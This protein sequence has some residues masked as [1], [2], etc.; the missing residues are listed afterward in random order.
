MNSKK[1]QVDK[2]LLGKRIKNIRQAAALNMAEFGELI[3]GANKGL[4]SKWEKGSSI[5]GY[6]RLKKIAELGGTSVEE[7][8]S[9]ESMRGVPPFN[10]SLEELNVLE[11]VIIKALEEEHSE[12]FRKSLI[13]S[14]EKI[15]IRRVELQDSTN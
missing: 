11:K 13:S 9:I 12:A 15:N 1:D 14:L 2:S 10:F 4:V 3:L 5:P 7:L 6:E 8:L